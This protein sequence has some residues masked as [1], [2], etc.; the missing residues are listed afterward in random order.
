MDVVLPLA[1]CLKLSYKASKMHS[2]L[3]H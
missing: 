1:N 2:G 3:D